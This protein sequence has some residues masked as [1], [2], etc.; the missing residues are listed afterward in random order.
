MTSYVLIICENSTWLRDVTVALDQSGFD[1]ELATS[2][3]EGLLAAITFCPDVVIIEAGM[4]R[5]DGCQLAKALRTLPETRNIAMLAIADQANQPPPLDI[6]HDFDS[7]IAP[8]AASESVITAVLAA[9]AGRSTQEPGTSS[10]LEVPIVAPKSPA[11]APKKTR[12]LFLNASQVPIAAP[13]QPGASDQPGNFFAKWP[14]T[15][16]F[17]VPPSM[18]AAMAANGAE[19]L[20]EEEMIAKT[21]RAI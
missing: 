10:S 4:G 20:T 2:D 9:I 13:G 14:G 1:I 5:I 21:L 7:V 12:K 11:R 16:W 18:A 15:R 17:A 8:D 3:S 6:S 19:V